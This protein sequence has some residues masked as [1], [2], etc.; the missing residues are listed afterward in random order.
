MISATNL[1]Q[2]NDIMID[3]SAIDTNT[4]GEYKVKASVKDVNK[5]KTEKEFKVTVIAP[6]STDSDEVIVQEEIINA[7]VQKQLKILLK[8]NHKPAHQVVLVVKAQ[9]VQ[10]QAVV[11]V[12]EAQEVQDQ[13]VVLVVEAQEVQDQA[14]VLVVEAQEVQGQAVVLVVEAQEVQDQA[15]VLVVEAQEV[16]VLEDLVQ[17][18]FLLKLIRKMQ[19]LWMDKYC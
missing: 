6:L 3:Y 16:L 8:R 1:A 5:N 17:V 9:E 12:V 18:I 19:S 13:A 11:L 7:D 14:V 2:L 4:L 10:D 15:V